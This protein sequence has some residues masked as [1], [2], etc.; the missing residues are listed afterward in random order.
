MTLAEYDTISQERALDKDKV[1]S[2][3]K[4]QAAT[5]SASKNGNGGGYEGAD[6]NST[7][8]LLNVASEYGTA[9][10]INRQEGSIDTISVEIVDKRNRQSSRRNNRL[11]NSSQGRFNLPSYGD[12]GKGGN[13]TTVGGILSEQKHFAALNKSEEGIA[14]DLRNSLE[15]QPQMTNGVAQNKISSGLNYMRNQRAN[16]YSTLQSDGPKKS[17]LWS[18]AVP[19]LSESMNRQTSSGQGQPNATH[20]SNSRKPLRPNMTQERLFHMRNNFSNKRSFDK[21][22][23]YDQSSVIIE[24]ITNTNQSVELENIPILNNMP[25]DRLSSANLRRPMSSSK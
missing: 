20:K 7:N 16:K 11:I 15:N 4:N 12:G 22:V 19:A 25:A 13:N 1:I 18:A 2:A 23:S 9:D 5:N 24:A 10:L 6:T 14:L 8:N 21:V 17:R 3:Q